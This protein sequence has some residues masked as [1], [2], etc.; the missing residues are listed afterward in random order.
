[1]S[2]LITLSN[3]AVTRAGHRMVGPVSL[4]VSRG[5][6]LAL[7]GA[8][9]SGKTT[10]LRLLRGDMTPDSGGERIYDFGDG[11]QESVIGLRQRIAMVSADMQDFYSLHARR[12]PGRAVVLSGFF[13]TPLLYESVSPEQEAAA[14]AVINQLGISALADAG[15]GTLSTG[16]VRKLFIARALVGRPD[17]LLLDECLE[18]LDVPS[19]AEVLELLDGVAGHITLV[20]AAHRAEDVPSCVERSVLLEQGSIRKEGAPHELLPPL[21]SAP[22][23]EGDAAPAP[24]K[25]GDFLLRLS[26]VSVVADGQRILH[27]VDW[28]VWPGE[29]WLVLGPNGAGKSS[30]LKVVMSELAPYAD[31]EAGTG[32]VEVLG[33][34]TMDEA[35]PKIGVVSPALQTRYGRELGWRVTALETVLSGFRG[36]VGMLDTPT[37][38]E[39]R[40]G[41]DWLERLGL[42]QVA[43]TPLR[44]LSYGQQ[45]RLFLARAM[46]SLPELLL[47]D[48]PMAGL[49]PAARRRM[50]G[51]VQRVAEAGTP[52]VLVT[53]H[54]EDVLPAINR[55]LVMGKG[56]VCFAGNRSDYEASAG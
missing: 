23:L 41:R 47:L 52:V 25:E 16:Q 15:M 22:T 31:G 12:A 51:L 54:Q 46:V 40:I 28:D 56:R 4:A 36:S 7:L 37:N 9:G 14:Q 21:D 43:D 26:N 27:N 3:A 45:R 19:R 30:V 11:P 13:D 32:T 48:E 17:V 33:G 8:N 29:N 44:N 10:L 18:G 35:R 1:M 20:V 53:H 38:E 5:E 42:E 2:P 39:I 34:M 50:L 49:D 55:V 6:H 24:D